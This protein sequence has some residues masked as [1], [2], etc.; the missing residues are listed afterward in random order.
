MKENN[1]LMNNLLS[2]SHG[3]FISKT[4]IYKLVFVGYL[5]KKYDIPMNCKFDNHLT[6]IQYIKEEISKSSYSQDEVNLLNQCLTDLVNDF[7]LNTSGVKQIVSLINEYPRE[8]YLDFIR[9]DLKNFIEKYNADMP[10]ELSKL[11]LKIL[12]TKKGGKLADLIC[13]NGNFLTIATEM[14]SNVS[15]LGLSKNKESLLNTELRLYMLNSDYQVDYDSET[16]IKDSFSTYD[17]IFC[18]LPPDIKDKNIYYNNFINT[19][20]NSVLWKYIDNAISM[21]NAKGKAIFILNNAPLFK[22]T[23]LDYRKYLIDN[24]LVEAII[25]LPSNILYHTGISTMMLV[26]SKN[27]NNMVN[28]IDATN[29]V[30]KDTKTSNKLDIDKIYD[31]YINSDNK[32]SDLTIK[33][34]NY[35][36]IPSNYLNDVSKSMINPVKL[37]DY[38]DVYRGYRGVKGENSE[39]TIKIIQVSNLNADFIDIN[40]LESTNYDASMNKDLLKDK[41]IVFSRSANNFQ[42]RMLHLKENEKVIASENIIVLRINDTKSLNPYYLEEYLNSEIGKSS[43]FANQV[44]SIV[45][46]FQISGLNETYIDLIPMSKQLEIENLSINKYEEMV[47]N[48]SKINSINSSINK[49][50]GNK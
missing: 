6:F 27:N 36:F 12:N 31:A 2:L 23:D 43:I 18:L 44:K 32:M 49:L 20:S 1:Q 40:E 21:L 14:S 7:N 4:N 37:K 28:M 24:K 8:A 15:L 17:S 30:I 10:E 26:L 35:S 42:C 13:G 47:I 11:V 50:L 5:T 48:K 34:K 19:K 9:L 45:T 33:D 38:V 3:G 41:D 46:M 29:M 22:N 25:E 39:E 16:I